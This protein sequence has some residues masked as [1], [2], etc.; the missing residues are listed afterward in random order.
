MGTNYYVV[1]PEKYGL[2]DWK[3]GHL[4]KTSAAGG[5]CFNCNKSARHPHREGSMDCCP[6]CGNTREERSFRKGWDALFSSYEAEHGRREGL[7][8]CYSFSFDLSPRTIFKL[9]TMALVLPR[10][11]GALAEITMLEFWDIIGR[12]RYWFTNM[13]GRGFS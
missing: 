1:E 6:W 3:G 8:A 4:G 2:P 10:S 5:W 7:M 13:I 9:P 11:G 12:A